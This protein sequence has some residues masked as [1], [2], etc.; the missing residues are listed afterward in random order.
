MIDLRAIVEET[1]LKDV[2][3]FIASG[4]VVFRTGARS[5]AALEQRLEKHLLARLGYTVPTFVRTEDEVIAILAKQPFKTVEPGN[6]VTVIL[7]REAIP[8]K[9]AAVFL[10]VRSP[11]D[12]FFVEGRELYWR[13][14][15]GISAS[16]VW[17]LPEIKAL[18]LPASTMRN[19]NTLH[20]LSEKFGF[21][22][23]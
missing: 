7:C 19:R 9:A 22:S 17:T 23:P 3:T 4:N 10:S 11:A 15:A 18:S 5:A 8:A 6:T 2:A 21:G 12:S 13:T 20:R 16:T 1:G 14:D